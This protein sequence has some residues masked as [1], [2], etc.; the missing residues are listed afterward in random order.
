MSWVFPTAY[1]VSLLVTWQ[2]TGFI[3][4][5]AD[6]Q[7]DA[8]TSIPADLTIDS[9]RLYH[10]PRRGV[11]V[12]FTIQSI[13]VDASVEQVGVKPDGS[14]DVPSGPV[15]V[16]WFMLGPRPGE[17][18]SAVIAGHRGWY[19][20]RSAVFDNLHTLRAGDTVTVVSDDG[21]T[22]TFI[23]HSTRIYAPGAVAPE[24]FTSSSGTH[25]N[26]IT[27]SGTWSVL[28]QSYSERLVVFTD[29]AP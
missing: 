26:L 19:G 14:M 16:A 15:P 27:C 12:R 22:F 3:L 11:P 10:P 28:Q 2:F 21:V 8:T 7:V 23:V 24:V 25:L 9:S 1:V 4:Q 6:S 20:G 13:G 5:R 29:L 18:G 17:Q